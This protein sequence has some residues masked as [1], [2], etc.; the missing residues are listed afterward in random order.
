MPGV[1]EDTV[2]TVSRVGVSRDLT[3]LKRNSTVQ[4]SRLNYT[5]ASLQVAA[6]ARSSQ[7]KEP[8]SPAPPQ[9]VNVSHWCDCDPLGFL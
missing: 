8:I 6:R 3:S 5:T 7:Q 1:M 2:E 4:S 9:R